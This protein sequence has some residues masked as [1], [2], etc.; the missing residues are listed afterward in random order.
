MIDEEEIYP[1]DII[2]AMCVNCH[3]FYETTNKEYEDSHRPV[4][5]QCEW[6][7][8]ERNYEA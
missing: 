3:A 8:N 7:I 2:E 4:C 1:H 6:D 5:P